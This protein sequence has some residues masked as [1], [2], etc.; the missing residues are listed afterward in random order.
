MSEGFRRE[1]DSYI[2][3]GPFVH[4]TRGLKVQLIPF[5]FGLGLVY[6]IDYC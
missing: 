2:A 6:E 1:N 3:P 4:L 5:D